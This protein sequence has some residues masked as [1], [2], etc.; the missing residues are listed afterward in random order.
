VVGPVVV[1]RP[2]AV[3]ADLPCD[4]VVVASRNAVPAL[5]D[6]YKLLPL[7]A[8]GSATAARAVAAGFAAVWDSCGD[9]ADL[10]RL[11]RAR[12]PGGSRLLLVHGMGQGD[13]LAAGLAA[14]GFAVE[15]AEGYAMLPAPRFP[16]SAEAALRGGLVHAATFLSAETARAFVR[17]VPDALISRLTDVSAVA[18]G[19]KAAE[20]L[21]LLPWRRV[22][23]SLKPTLDHVLA[24]L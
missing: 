2:G 14:A 18:I 13:A 3:A 11:T 22:R 9:A 4:A 17:L 15:R 24:L 16:P 6:C 1:L 23:V 7:F 10:V 12:L 21:S 20:V 8:V 19:Q 5:P